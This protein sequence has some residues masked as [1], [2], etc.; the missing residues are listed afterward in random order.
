MLWSI[1]QPVT[2][3]ERSGPSDPR[4]LLLLSLLVGLFYGRLLCGQSLFG[5]DVLPYLLSQ[6]QLIRQ[7]LLRGRLP[8]V[9][10]YILCGTP[11]LG[12]VV[13]APLYPLNVLLLVG[14]PLWAFHLFVF[15]H[16]W[17]AAMASYALL[18]RG[19][20][21]GS[22]TSGT[23]AFAYAAGGYLW[24]TVDHNFY[25]AAPWVPLALLGLLHLLD[26]A[27]RVSWRRPWITALGAYALLFTC[28]CLQQAYDL[29]LFGGLLVV[30]TCVVRRRAYGRTGTA[31]LLLAYGSCVVLAAALAAPQLIPAAATA[32]RSY[33]SGGVSLAQAQEWSFAPIR[34]AEYLAPFLFGARQHDGL[35]LHRFYAGRGPWCDCVFVGVPL[36]VGLL[37]NR[38]GP[39]RGVLAWLALV[40][41]IAF[42]LALGRLTP[43]YGWAH[44]VLPRFNVFR[45]PSKYL[46]WVHFCLVSAGSMGLHRASQSAGACRRLRLAAGTALGVVGIGWAAL[47]LAVLLRPGAYAAGARALGSHWPVRSVYL[48][49]AG[50]LAA[51]AV[52][53]LSVR[54][55]ARG[56]RAGAPGLPRTAFVA[57]AAH[58]LVLS[59]VIRWT[60]P[61]RMLYET[62]TV[63]EWIPDQDRRVH[64]VHSNPKTGIPDTHP[65]W[66]RDPV[67]TRKL[68]MFARL[69]HNTPGL[70]GLRAMRGFSPV[71]DGAFLDYTDYRKRPSSAILDLTSVSHVVVSSEAESSELPPDMQL[72]HVDRSAGHAVLRNRDCLPR[73]YTTAHHVLVAPDRVVD[74]AFERVAA[75]ASLREALSD[76][77]TP[78]STPGLSRHP[79]IV[80]SRLPEDYSTDTEASLPQAPD[81]IEDDPG[82]ITALCLGPAWLVVRDW[83]LPG[84]S[85]R[86]D[87]RSCDLVEA[88]GGFMA[89]FVPRGDHRVSLAYRPPGFLAGCLVALAAA[90]VVGFAVAFRRP[91]PGCLPSPVDAPPGSLGGAEEQACSVHGVAPGRDW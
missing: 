51:S 31:W 53:L 26:P 69:V 61:A 6:K 37:G 23:G 48:W 29:V 72:V 2:P 77:A 64:R 58:L 78:S 21:L 1:L 73:I 4:L 42:M 52:A 79:A 10:P 22:W 81:V 49:Q 75:D 56:A 62:P 60:I 47:T 12:N 45:H 88:D 55:A 20:G 40:A 80:V 84:W 33:R 87:G 16:Y 83:F 36:V 19:L 90:A 34:I 65:R 70:F 11:L 14:S 18:R 91:A 24:S 66:H 85:A 35:M 38:L 54:W 46:F 71:A 86:V 39:R 82:R 43:V 68:G 44:A 50:T 74:A 27:R 30:V 15:S 13:A 7:Q 3:T 28:G 89:V 25:A 67:V 59:V 32:A 57:T 9:N 5:S 63:S 76:G 41:L 17:L 8:L